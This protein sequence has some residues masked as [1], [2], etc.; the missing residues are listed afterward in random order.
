MDSSHKEPV[1]WKAFPY[2]NVNQHYIA[3]RFQILTK[4][5]VTVAVDAVM[6][7]RVFDPFMAVVNVENAMGAT[8]LLAQTTLR[9]ILGTKT[10]A[11]ILSE[12]E[13]VSH[14][15]QVRLELLTQIVMAC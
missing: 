15:M 12:R 6:Y 1:M 10:L 11:E 7:Y 3:C 14:Q 2:H 4:D 13:A 5:S 8:G 9:N